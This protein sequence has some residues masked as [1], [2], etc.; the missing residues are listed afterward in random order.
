MTGKQNWRKAW[1]IERLVV[2]ACL[3]PGHQ[4]LFGYQL[5]AELSPRYGGPPV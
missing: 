4:H 5:E 3:R 2:P 1:R